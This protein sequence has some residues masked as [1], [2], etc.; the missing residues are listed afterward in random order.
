MV[1]SANF[2]IDDIRD[3]ALRNRTL[4]WAHQHSAR[5]IL[6]ARGPWTTYCAQPPA[7]ECQAQKYFMSLVVTNVTMRRAY[8]KEELDRVW[9]AGVSLPR[10]DAMPCL[11][12]SCVLQ[13]SFKP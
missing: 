10:Q 6:T 7:P 1:T 11:L 4:C 9:N 13:F 12:L 2:P 8:F 3:D 5:V